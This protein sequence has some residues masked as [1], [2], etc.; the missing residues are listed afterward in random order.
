[1]VDEIT[2]APSLRLNVLDHAGSRCKD[3]DKG[4][5]EDAENSEFLR[6]RSVELQDTGNWKRQDPDVKEEI[7]NREA[8]QVWER[9]GAVLFVIAVPGCREVGATLKARQE[10][11]DDEPQ[12][13]HYNSGDNAPVKPVFLSSDTEDPPIE[14]QSA[15]LG[16]C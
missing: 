12:Y 5:E 16:A 8:V 2:R 6:E 14:E 4:K 11:E 9:Q 3:T 10:L 1:M 7:G 13:H 15:K